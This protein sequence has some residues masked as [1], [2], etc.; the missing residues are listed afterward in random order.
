LGKVA[1]KASSPRAKWAFVA[2]TPVAVIKNPVPLLVRLFKKDH[3][4][5]CAAD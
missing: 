2:M 4:W 5:F 1:S 3:C